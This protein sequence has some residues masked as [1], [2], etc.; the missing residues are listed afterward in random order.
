[1]A[2]IDQALGATIE[3]YF[4]EFLMKFKNNAD[5]AEPAYVTQVRRMRAEEMHTLF[6]DYTHFEKFSE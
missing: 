3:R 6:I 2:D 4:V 1:M 5:D